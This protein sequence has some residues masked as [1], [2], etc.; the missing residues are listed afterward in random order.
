MQI[1]FKNNL[2]TTVIGVYWGV[3]KRQP[4]PTKMTH[5]KNRNAAEIA[6]L[7]KK[8]GISA[9][10]LARALKVTAQTVYNLLK[11]QS[12]DQL[13]DH[14]LLVLDNWEGKP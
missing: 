11:G 12:S 8:H 7:M 14:A 6:E 2:T 13:I 5:R 4:R 1:Y 3:L 9:N 10:E